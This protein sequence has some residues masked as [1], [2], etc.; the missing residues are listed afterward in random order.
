M[1][2]VASFKLCVLPALEGCLLVAKRGGNFLV[3]PGD[4]V[5]PPPPQTWG[6]RRGLLG[7]PGAPAPERGVLG[8]L[9]F[10]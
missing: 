4:L 5:L 8:P 3:D 10:S 6:R 9:L 7:V 1:E 2:P